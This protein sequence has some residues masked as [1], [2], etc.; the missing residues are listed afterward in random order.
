M[1]KIILFPLGLPS[2]TKCWFGSTCPC[3]SLALREGLQSCPRKDA[4]FDT[5]FQSP[6]ISLLP[7]LSLRNGSLFRLS[8]SEISLPARCQCYSSPSVASIVVWG[9]QSAACL[10]VLLMSLSLR[11]RKFPWSKRPKDDSCCDYIWICT[12]CCDGTLHEL[13]GCSL[14]SPSSDT[15]IDSSLKIWLEDKAATLVSFGVEIL[16]I[17][18][19]TL[20]LL[21]FVTAWSH[22]YQCLRCVEYRGDL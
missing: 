1:S 17:L 14:I 6:A 21:V 18:L 10:R 8:A 22:K 20:F 11:L 7:I 19:A 5:L 4:I 15:L 12:I 9:N 13:S 3:I 2:S 16:A